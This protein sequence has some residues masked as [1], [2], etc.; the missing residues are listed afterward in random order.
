MNICIIVQGPSEHISTLRSSYSQWNIPV[1]YSTWK[2]YEH[3]YHSNETVIYNTKPKETGTQNILLQQISTYNGLLKASSLGYTHAIKIRSDMIWTNLPLFLQQL[4]SDF[5][6]FCHYLHYT[7]NHTLYSYLCDYIQI[8][9]IH[10]LLQIW[11]FSHA[12]CDFPEQYITK[13]TLSLFPPTHIKFFGSILNSHI[14]IYWI[15]RN[16]RLSHNNKHPNYHNSFI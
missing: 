13:R 4:S 15:K 10:D 5:I 12:P 9:P 3:L 6:Y 16:L 11:N 2:G 14:D 1:I 8:G 7:R